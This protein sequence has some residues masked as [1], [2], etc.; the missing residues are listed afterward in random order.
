[1]MKGTIKILELQ[2]EI[3]WNDIA[4]DMLKEP[5]LS[6]SCRVKAIVE[7]DGWYTKY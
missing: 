6:M 2:I 1:M 5:A 3:A 4:D 7:A